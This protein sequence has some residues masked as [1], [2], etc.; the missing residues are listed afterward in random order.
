MTNHPYDQ[1]RPADGQAP[2][3]QLDRE[4]QLARL[5]K[6]ERDIAAE[7]ERL[8][9]PSAGSRH[10]HGPSG[11][12]RQDPRYDDPRFDGVRGSEQQSARRDNPREDNPRRDNPRDN[13]PRFDDP[14]GG[15]RQDAR[16]DD[17]RGADPRAADP[18]YGKHQE[19]VNTVREVELPD[20][21]TK[22]TESQR[23]AWALG[24]QAGLS[25][26][27]AGGRTTPNPFHP[28]RESRV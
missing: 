16:H 8:N 18:R 21:E 17:P 12:D 26:A 23:E 10:Q 9:R 20:L 4:A 28:L 7:R 15:E 24:Y 19:Q 27:Q 1:G 22:V 11:D 13:D 14:H 25:D 3:D 5:D 6:L 2:T